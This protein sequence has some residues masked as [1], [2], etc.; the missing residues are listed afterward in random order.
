MAEGAA[1]VQHRSQRGLQHAHRARRARQDPGVDRRGAPER[2]PVHRERHHH[3]PLAALASLYRPPAAGQQ[4]HKELGEG[5]RSGHRHLQAERE[6]LLA[7]ARAG[8]PVRQVDP[9]GEHRDQLGPRARAGA[10]AAEGKGWVGLRHPAWRQVHHVHRHVQILHDDD[11]AEPA[12]LPGDI[13]QGDLAQLRHHPFGLGGPDV[14]H[15]RRQG[16]AGPRGAEE[17]A[18]CAERQDEQDAERNRRRHP[19]AARDQRRRRARGRYAGE[20][21][22]K[23]EGGFG[24]H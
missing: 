10:S 13:R 20:Q 5:H 21:G 14:G 6:E 15:R 22:H 8:H 3:R 16:A 11:I 1:E 18:G 7:D 4:V 9:V 17:R 23:F 24:R 19:E 12:L 2:R